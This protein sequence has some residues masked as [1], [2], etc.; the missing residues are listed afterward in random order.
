[1]CRHDPRG[2]T[3]LAI[4]DYPKAA[5]RQR[6]PKAPTVVRRN[7]FVSVV[8]SC[9]NE[10]QGVAL[11][12][13]DALTGLRRAGLEG[14]VIVV[15]NG[16][17]DRSAELA[18]RAGARVIHEARVGTGAA[19]LRGIEAATGDIIV[20][21]DADGT[22]D[23]QALG[24][25]ARGVERGSDLVIANRM[26]SIDSGAMPWPHRHLGTPA[27]N[28]LLRLL[29]GLRVSDS[30]SGF[31]AFRRDAVR[32]L[33]L[34]TPGFESVTELLLRASRR[35]WNVSEVPT[36]YRQRR[37]TSKLRS[38]PDGWKHLRM[39]LVY[40][41]HFTL[42]TPGLLAVGLGLLLTMLP[43]VRPDGIAIAGIRWAPVFIGPL[44]IILGGQATVVGA[45]AA[46]RIRL[47]P[48][49]LTAR[50]Q[51]LD[52]PDA[53]DVLLRRFLAIAAAGMLTD[54]VL[55]GLW[56][57]DRG[58]ER[59]LAFA[60]LAQAAIVVGIGGITSLAAAELT[61]EAIE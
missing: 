60:G 20:T 23:L 49:R 31:R 7:S 42:L 53:V 9:L 4:V 32:D 2:S 38:F 57:S 24:D 41:P 21:A 58:G 44:L 1:M 13:R 8:L 10:E 43:L 12:V 61:R 26:A 47:N 30:H 45:L 48:G 51:F 27:F 6:A 34:Q 16:S 15:D 3:E 35:G 19:T 54:A 5:V 37:G 39:L 11:A 29:T 33:G 22:Y 36:R 17:T 14:E 55:F 56:V 59:M 46:H 40:S 52:R 18:R 50:L 28:L 25:L